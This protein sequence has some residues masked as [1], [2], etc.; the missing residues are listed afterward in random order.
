MSSKENNR[1]R[2]LPS[3][4]SNLRLLTF[5]FIF[6][7]FLIFG[8]TVLV[9]SSQT[10]ENIISLT[11]S[12]VQSDA[13]IAA[14]QIDGDRFSSL[15]PGDENDPRF[16]AIRDQLN[17]IRNTD[18]KIRYVYTMRKSGSGVVFVVDGDY[19][20]TSDAA[21]LGEVY[22]NL[23]PELLEGFIRP[24]SDP[25]FTSDEWG[26]FLSGYAPIRN[27]SGD[28]VGIIGIDM[29][30]MAV[31]ERLNYLNGIFFLLGMISILAAVVGIIVI[32]RRRSL[33]EEV[34]RANRNYL[35]QIF[36]SVRAGIVIIDAKSHTI[37]D[38]NPSALAMIGE[39]KENCIGKV[40]HLFICPAESGRCP[41]S[42]L[43]QSVNNLEQV[44]LT[45]G[46]VSIPIIKYVVPLVLDGRPCLLET[47]VDITDRKKAE[48]NLLNAIQKL[49]ILSVVTR[50]D[51]ITDIY[52]LEGYIELIVDDLPAIQAH[53]LFGKIEWVMERI[54][55]KSAF[56]K[57]YDESGTKEP[58]W[59]DVSTSVRVAM[60]RLRTTRLSVSS[61]LRDLEI[62]ADPLL[63]KVFFNLLDNTLRH[64]ISATDVRIAWHIPGNSLVL[65]YEDNGRGIPDEDKER[66]FE[67]GVGSLTGLGLF[68]AREVLGLTGITIR[69]CGEAGTGARFEISVPE[70]KYRLK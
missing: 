64:G 40:C 50:N 22:P 52:A 10:K 8:T 43:G 28:V 24:A 51:I 56:F 61:D 42:D 3:A 5:L 30:Q 1:N 59:Q 39:S 11:R 48:D 55:L 65:T 53:P 58:V 6:F 35:T 57:D 69:E 20:H 21:Y 18:S 47:F 37:V 19:G 36:E 67:R 12:E 66:I 17:A 15:R 60:E 31:I 9:I 45:T 70:G 7:I 29:D 38:A 14:L 49:K 44:L 41:I 23:F 4:F 13:A 68:F 62:F 34:M 54:R 46:G 63:E 16:L 33:D 26:T 2:V 32:E 25:G 27:S